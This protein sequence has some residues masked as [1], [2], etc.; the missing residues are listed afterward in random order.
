MPTTGANAVV[1]N[2]SLSTKLRAVFDASAMA[3]PSCPSL[4]DCIHAGPPLSPVIFDILLRF[5]R[6]KIG[7]VA[8][9][10]KAFLNI[11]INK[12]Q[13]NLAR[14]LW[15]DDVN[16][17][18]PTLVVYRFCC[19]IFGMNCSPFLLNATLK[20]HVTQHYRND[21]ILAERVLQDLYFDDWTTGGKSEVEALELSRK[22]RACFA[23]GSFN[24]RKWA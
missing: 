7:L 10:E 13:R 23:A 5:R 22:A 1:R 17:T 14:F 12:E 19:V 16:S 18:D 4:N 2:E 9:I 15:I 20:N 3:K 21:P 8:D 24:L 11:A 6:R